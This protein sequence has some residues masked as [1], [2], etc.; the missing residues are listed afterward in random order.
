MNPSPAG[1][2][3]AHD[4]QPVREDLWPYLARGPAGWLGATYG[5]APVGD[6]GIDV[7]GDARKALIAAL[8]EVSG[9]ESGQQRRH[10]Q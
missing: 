7:E 5:L 4:L 9:P 3:C 10:P 6:E 2:R 8:N 1:C